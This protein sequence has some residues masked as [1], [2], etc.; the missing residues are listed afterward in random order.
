MHHV[1]TVDLEEYFQVGVFANVVTPAEWT[2]LPS[3]LQPSVGRLLDL[4]DEAGVFATFFADDWIA[5]HHR[6]VIQRLARRGHELGVKTALQPGDPPREPA[7][8]RAD[9]RSARGRLE[10]VSGRAVYG[11]RG[12]RESLSRRE[13]IGLDILIEEGFLYDSSSADSWI[14]HLMGD[15]TPIPHLVERPAGSLLTLPVARAS[16]LGVPLGPAGRMLRQLPYPVAR[17]C[18]ARHEKDGQS[19][20]LRIRSWEIDPYQ[21]RLS[22]A[23]GVRLRHYG[24]LERMLPR[25]ARLLSEFRFTSAERRFG[26]SGDDGEDDVWRESRGAAGG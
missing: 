16:A 7:A 3:R 8:F 22:R 14:D 11:H 23:L 18:L 2:S 20:V 26:L 25:L 12:G 21:P 1:L 5:S 6:G 9:L 24:G 19:A 15:R 4:F 13:E 10:D 17:K